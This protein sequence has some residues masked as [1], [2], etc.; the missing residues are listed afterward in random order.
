MSRHTSCCKPVDASG[1]Y[2]ADDDRKSQQ[3]INFG[4]TGTYLALILS[5]A[6]TL[7]PRLLLTAMSPRPRECHTDINDLD[8]SIMSIDGS[9][10]LTA[11]TIS[12]MQETSSSPLHHETRQGVLGFFPSSLDRRYL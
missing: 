2:A 6:K 11:T 3:N 5:D 4:R 9:L 8:I 12:A 1:D 7:T 10:V